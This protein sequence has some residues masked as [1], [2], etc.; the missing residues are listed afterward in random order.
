MTIVQLIVPLQAMFGQLVSSPSA[1]SAIPEAIS[2]GTSCQ[3]FGLEWDN[4]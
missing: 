2:E 3:G 4:V 1:L